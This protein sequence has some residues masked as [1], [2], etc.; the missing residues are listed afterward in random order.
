MGKT[1]NKPFS[2][3]ASFQAIKQCQYSSTVI[4]D[5]VSDDDS[6]DNNISPSSFLKAHLNDNYSLFTQAK[7]LKKPP[8][9]YLL[10]N[11]DMRCKLLKESS[12][13]SVAE[14]SKK[15]GDQWRSLPDDKHQFYIEKALL[16]KEEHLRKYPNFMYTRRSKA[17]ISEAKKYIEIGKSSPEPSKAT[18]VNLNH[19]YY[20]EYNTLSSMTENNSRKRKKRRKQHTL[21]DGRQRDPRGRKKKRDKHPLAP[22]HPMSAY[23]YFLTSVYPQMSLEFPGSTVGPISKSISRAWHAMSPDEQLPWKHKAECDKARYAHEM[24]IYMANHYNASQAE[25]KTK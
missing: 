14:I 3:F 10:F 11:K 20:P 1:T 12:K 16:L 7:R 4:V 5:H 15:V 17:E 6:A 18:I 13:I 21:S 24:E 22:K 9:A 2:K 19:Y 23:L 25:E 8:N